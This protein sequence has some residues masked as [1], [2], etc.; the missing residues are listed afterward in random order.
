MFYLNYFVMERALIGQ[1][2][3][4]LHS[5]LRSFEEIPVSEW[6]ATR[7]QNCIPAGFLFLAGVV[8]YRHHRG[9]S[10]YKLDD[11]YIFVQ[12]MLPYSPEMSNQKRRGFGQ[13]Y[14]LYEP[15]EL[16][17]DDVALDETAIYQVMPDEHFRLI[18]ADG[19]HRKAECVALMFAQMCEDQRLENFSD[20]A[21]PKL[22][23]VTF[24][25]KS[26]GYFLKG[27]TYHVWAMPVGIPNFQEGRLH[28]G[29]IFCDAFC[30]IPCVIDFERE[31]FEALQL[32]EGDKI[33][34]GMFIYRDDMLVYNE[35]RQ[36]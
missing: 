1:K 20:G 12:S 11:D 31:N 7:N 32:S 18:L 26:C 29:W 15:A 4:P 2:R 13:V 16:Y 28:K 36:I 14:A 10:P 8:K 9:L 35:H 3:S 34:N 27:R 21:A 6:K 24:Q 25:Q 22:Y 23:R 19:E 33:A 30:G 5:A 17:D